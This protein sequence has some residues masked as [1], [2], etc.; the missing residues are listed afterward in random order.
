MLVDSLD[1]PIPY[2]VSSKELRSA[3]KI[4]LVLA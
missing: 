3:A 2:L 4:N 1:L